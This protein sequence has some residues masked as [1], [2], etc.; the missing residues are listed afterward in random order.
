MSWVPPLTQAWDSGILTSL[1]PSPPLLSNGSF[2]GGLLPDRHAED[3]ASPLRS[4]PASQPCPNTVF[5]G[6]SS[7]LRPTGRSS[8]TREKSHPLLIQCQA[9]G[10]WRAF[11]KEPQHGATVRPFFLYFFLLPPKSFPPGRG[12]GGGR[13]AE[14][15][16]RAAERQ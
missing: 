7:S 13:L 10:A 11:I 9:S 16:L 2:R 6:G 3:K 8:D 14:V 15:T 1:P 12:G 4:L 5:I